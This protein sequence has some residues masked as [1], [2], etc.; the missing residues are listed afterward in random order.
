MSYRIPQPFTSRYLCHQ[1]RT[2]TFI[3]TSNLV[4]GKVSYVVKL[5]VLVS[6]QML[7]KRKGAGVVIESMSER[8]CVNLSPVLDEATL[9]V[10]ER[11]L[12]VEYVIP[13]K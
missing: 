9:K 10:S 2:L 13:H 7:S 6:V 11:V 1:N 3:D 12:S 8:I 4:D 5:W